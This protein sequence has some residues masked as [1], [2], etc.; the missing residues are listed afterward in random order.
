[1]FRERFAEQ[2]ANIYGYDDMTLF[3]SIAWHSCCCVSAT[4]SN[5]MAS[6]NMP[7]CDVIIIDEE[8]KK[9][10]ESSFCCSTKLRHTYTFTCPNKKMENGWTYFHFPPQKNE[11][12]FFI[13]LALSRTSYSRA[14]FSWHGMCVYGHFFGI[15]FNTSVIK[16]VFSVS[17]PVRCACV[18]VYNHFLYLSRW[19]LAAS[20]SRTH[21]RTKKKYG[22][23]QLI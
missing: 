12:H 14:H 11:I 2:W 18:F 8:E 19:T 5:E 1:M 23:K 13:S 7:K 4:G 22:K 20:C 10:N 16:L 17:I 21:T 15:T 3:A 6:A 9:F